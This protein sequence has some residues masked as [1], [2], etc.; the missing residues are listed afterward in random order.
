MIIW[1]LLSVF[2]VSFN[3]SSKRATDFH[4]WVKYLELKVFKENITPDGK[5]RQKQS[6]SQPVNLSSTQPLKNPSAVK[7]CIKNLVVLSP[8]HNWLASRCTL[9]TWVYL[10][11]RLARH[12]VDLQW[13][14]TCSML[15]TRFQCTKPGVQWSLVEKLNRKHSQVHS[16]YQSLV[17]RRNQ[18]CKQYFWFFERR[19]VGK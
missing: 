8:G 18:K 10:R 3:I 9:K 7:I 2:R 19:R 11:L 4:S 5:T 13:L 15:S 14:H 17:T 6:S 16:S 1:L 12:Y